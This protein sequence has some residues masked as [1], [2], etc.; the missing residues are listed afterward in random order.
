MA[1]KNKKRIFS[2][3]HQLIQTLC[4]MDH[5]SRWYPVKTQE[6]SFIDPTKKNVDEMILEEIRSHAKVLAGSGM[7]LRFDPK[8]NDL[9]VN[10]NALVSI[11][12]CMGFK[13]TM[14]Q[15]LK[16]KDLRILLNKSILR[17]KNKDM[18]IHV[19]H[20]QVI[21]MSMSPD[22]RNWVQAYEDLRREHRCE[23]IDMSK[24]YFIPGVRLVVKFEGQTAICIK[25][26]LRK[27]N[28]TQKVS[29]VV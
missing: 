23:Q 15:E 4:E 7:Y 21:F 25:E 5:D 18:Y 27:R 6:I 8:L 24:T 26:N 28:K 16:R 10:E 2:S 1:K 29:K 9:P 14:L 11:C 17:S 3:E 20:N 19:W 12:Q 22:H 13:G